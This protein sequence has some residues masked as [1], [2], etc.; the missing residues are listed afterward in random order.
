M[1]ACARR[2]AAGQGHACATSH[3]AQCDYQQWAGC[4][5]QGQFQHRPHDQS[6]IDGN[7][8]TTS[9]PPRIEL[10]FSITKVV[11]F[12]PIAFFTVSAMLL[13]ASCVAFF[14]CLSTFFLI[15]VTILASFFVTA[16]TFF[17]AACC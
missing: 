15:V 1:A 5:S 9:L 12:P 7:L 11:Y 2:G 14:T 3:T 6:T 16:A 4:A 17:L 10:Y 8:A 13:F